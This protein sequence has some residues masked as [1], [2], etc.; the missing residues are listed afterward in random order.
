MGKFCTKCG[1]PLAEGELCTC[2]M[3]KPPMAQNPQGA[4]NGY[5][6]QAPQQMQGGGQPQFR[7]QMPNAAQMQNRQQMQGGN[8]AQNRQAAS[9][10]GQA[11]FQQQM[12]GGNPAQNMQ[13]APAGQQYNSQQQYAYQQQVQQQY[14]QVHRAASGY[15]A[16]TIGTFINIV[17][18]PI[19]TGKNMIAF[20]DMQVIVSLIIL[21]A[22]FSGFFS[23]AVMAKISGISMGYIK[24][25]IA[26]GFF[27]TVIFSSLLSFVLAALL[28]GGNLIIKNAVT[29]KQMLA[30]VAVKSVLLVL[31]SLVSIIVFLLIPSA[32]F[33]FFYTGSLWGMIAIALVMPKYVDGK[34][35]KLVLIQFLSAILFLI[36]FIIFAQMCW[37]AYIPDSVGS[38]MDGLDSLLKDPSTVLQSLF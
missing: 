37:K 9:N 34:E 1:K 26:R 2:Q 29:Y 23:I 31:T 36:C 7:Q 25:P 21:Q 12:Q 6:R 14:Q 8:F 32:G 22:V 38:M 18:N 20:A 24:M 33:F 27:V 3:G 13:G 11:Q 30:C 17:K 15:L 19:Q 5:Q 35:D 16:K 28:L 4:P 10:V